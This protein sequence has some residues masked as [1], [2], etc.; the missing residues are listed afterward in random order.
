MAGE[1]F[2]FQ[3]DIANRVVL[4][5]QLLEIVEGALVLRHAGHAGHVEEATEKL[6]DVFL[7]VGIL[8]APLAVVEVI[9]ELR[10]PDIDHGRTRVFHQFREIGQA[11]SL[12]L[13]S[14]GDEHHN[15]GQQAELDSFLHEITSR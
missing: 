13:G 8:G 5:D 14:A 10:D 2:F 9:T 4:G 1:V 12:R 6:G 15:R 3:A 7:A 11:G